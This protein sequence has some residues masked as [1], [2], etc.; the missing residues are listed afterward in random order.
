MY[1]SSRVQAGRALAKQM[2]KKYRYENCAVIALNDGGVM[3][4]AQIATE[5]HC[6]LTMILSEEVTLPREPMAIGSIA[7]DGTFSFNT[8]YSSGEIDELNAE[9][10]Q[11]IEQEKFTKLHHMHQLIG[12]SG[13][14]S[15]DL[16]RGHTLILVSDGLQSSFSLDAAVQFLKPINYEKLVVATPLASVQAVDRMHILADEIYCLSVITDYLDTPHY[17][18]KQDVPDHE[19]VIKTIEQIILNWK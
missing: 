10:Y 12:S 1:F 5:L 15:R 13:L 7:Q 8:A 11:L 19:T 2:V 16:L 6:V 18:D 9:Y 3:V 17:Y 14:M 4:G